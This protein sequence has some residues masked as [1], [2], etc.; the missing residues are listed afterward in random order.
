[1][2]RISWVA[3]WSVTLCIAVIEFGATAEAAVVGTATLVKDP[4]NGIPFG[5]PDAALGAPWVSYRLSVTATDGD[6]I[7]AVDAT[8]SGQLHQRWIASNVDGV[9][10]TATHSST[11]QANGDSHFAAI[12]GGLQLFFGNHSEDN[13]ATGSPLS[14]S[15]SDSAGWG[16]GTSMSAAFP[17]FDGLR[18]HRHSEMV[19]VG[20]TGG[21]L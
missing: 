7:Q 8:I 15:N 1:M 9:Y 12:S 14:P 11:N 19:T 17:D 18:L 2:N 10:D 3:V 13:P 21:R 20:H 6:L 5:A 4:A 16:V